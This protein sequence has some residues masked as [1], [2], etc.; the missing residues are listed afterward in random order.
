MAGFSLHKN[1]QFL[2]R[3]ITGLSVILNH[4]SGLKHRQYPREYRSAHLVAL[5][6]LS[7]SFIVSMAECGKIRPLFGQ[8]IRKEV[9]RRPVKVDKTL[10]EVLR[11]TTR[12]GVAGRAGQSRSA[13][14]RTESAKIHQGH[15]RCQEGGRCSLPRAVAR[16]RHRQG[17]QDDL[18]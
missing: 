12:R 9:A 18:L 11:P 16:N 10:D 5:R 2:T 7:F 3:C 6:P 14:G 4:S 13:A 8:G 1:V 17:P 15:F